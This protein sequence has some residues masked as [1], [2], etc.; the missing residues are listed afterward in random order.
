MPNTSL[1]HDHLED[2][3]KEAAGWKFTVEEF[4][5]IFPEVEYDGSRLYRGDYPFAVT[6]NGLR[7]YCVY[8]PAAGR[9]K[10]DITVETLICFENED[11]TQRT[12]SRY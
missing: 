8:N 12:H 3:L 11:G 2:R 9:D 7:V 10:Y 6:A 1:S 4:K 5:G